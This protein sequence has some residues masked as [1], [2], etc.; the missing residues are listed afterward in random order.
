MFR[1]LNNGGLFI[2]ADQ[3]LGETAWIEEMYR[4]A[5][6]GQVKERGVSDS[7][8]ASAL[9]RMKEDKMST[10]SSQLSWMKNAGF[11]DVNCWYKN[12]SFAVYSGRKHEHA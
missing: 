4:N 5:W 1:A 6:L 7:T 8:L 12:Y 9:E 10:L 3:V 2:N 11:A